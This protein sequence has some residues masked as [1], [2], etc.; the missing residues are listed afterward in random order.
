[1]FKKNFFSNLTDYSLKRTPSQAFVFY[2]AYAFLIVLIAAF[3]GALFGTIFGAGD[4][5]LA[6]RLGIFVATLS[7]AILSFVI[8][9]EKNLLN[10]YFLV[11][12]ALVVSLTALF[13]GV[14]TSLL[15]ATYFTTLKS[16]S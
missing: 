8:L 9:R 16:N 11:V 15:A 3:V 12:L 6:R 1:M 2:I 5:I 4:V 13:G 14:L 10:N 7:S